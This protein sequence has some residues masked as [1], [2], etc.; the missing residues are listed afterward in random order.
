MQRERA[1]QDV[2]LY[3]LMVTD[4][5]DKVHRPAGGR[6]HEAV[7]RAFGVEPNGCKL[8]AA[9]R[10]EPEEAGRAEAAVCRL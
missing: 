10:D 5:L 8:D 6:R 2:E 9:R 7:A 3:A 4:V 1:S